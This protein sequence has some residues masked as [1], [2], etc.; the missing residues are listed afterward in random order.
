MWLSTNNIDVNILPPE[1][2]SLKS[3][4]LIVIFPHKLE[5]EFSSWEIIYW[6]G[7]RQDFT[8]KNNSFP[9][10]RIVVPLGPITDHLP[11]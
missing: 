10:Q 9:T 8:I 1:P 6:V 4:N 2:E 7:T 3:L 5:P 11:R